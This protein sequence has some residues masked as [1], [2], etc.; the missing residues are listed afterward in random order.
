VDHLQIGR[1]WWVEWGTVTVQL[2]TSPSRMFAAKLPSG[3]PFAEPGDHVTVDTR[4]LFGLVAARAPRE[5]RR[6]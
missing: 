5:G 3:I 6:W 4:P 1:V 2:T